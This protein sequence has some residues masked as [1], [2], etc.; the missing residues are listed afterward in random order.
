MSKFYKNY[1]WLRKRYHVDRKT[2]E[3]IAKECNVSSVT[4]YNYLKIFKLKKG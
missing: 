1:E 3:E 2:P 4:I